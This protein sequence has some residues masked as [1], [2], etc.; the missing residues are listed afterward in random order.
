MKQP[1]HPWRDLD[2]KGHRLSVDDFLTTRV[3]RLGESL[4][5][6]LT[7]SYV[8]TAGLTQSQWRILSVM[9]EHPSMRMNELVTEAAVDKALVSR[10]LRQLEAL[11]LVLLDSVPNAP[12]KGLACK[13]SA[14][15]HRL[16]E[17]TIV[18]ARQAQTD[19]LRQLTPT[20]REVTYRAIMKLGALCES[21][22]TRRK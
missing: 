3:V 20:E 16:Y 11:G 22:D 17:R 14:K 1:L 9:A 15:G 19:M 10:V 18:L 7:Q 6:Q 5:R 12:R 4:R 8:D 21:S 2:E 13:L